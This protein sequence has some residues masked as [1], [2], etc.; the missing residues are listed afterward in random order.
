MSLPG[1]RPIW[2]ALAVVVMALAGSVIVTPS[3]T[4]EIGETRL[5]APRATDAGVIA[6]GNTHT[7]AILGDG[8]L[9]CWGRNSNGQL[10]IGNA[11]DQ[12]SP[13]RVGSA[14]DWRSVSAGGGTTCA[15]TTE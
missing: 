3:A 8:S 15:V 12:P 4:A 2:R 6:A 14:T 11:T 1:P 13:V 5:D 7:C 9:W 10:G